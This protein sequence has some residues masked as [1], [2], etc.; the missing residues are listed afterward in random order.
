MKTVMACGWP[1]SIERYVSEGATEDEGLRN[2]ESGLVHRCQDWE[3]AIPGSLQ[4]AIVTL[5]YASMPY[6][7]ANS[8][9]TA[10]FKV[11][12]DRQMHTLA[13][14]PLF[15]GLYG[16]QPYRSNYADL[17]TLWWMGKLLR[18]YGIEGRKD[19]LARDP[20]E[21]TLIA[22]PDFAEGLDIYFVDVALGEG[23]GVQEEVGV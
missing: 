19:P 13:T 8:C 4:H 1:F 20:Y 2:I 10:D 15:S 17:E 6:C 23:A 14:H 5:M 22:N 7:T 3:R 21:L 12:L 11:H 9:S 16:V 18:H